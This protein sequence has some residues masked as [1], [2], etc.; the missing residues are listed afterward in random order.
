MTPR[1]SGSRSAVERFIS[2]GGQLCD[3]VA[4]DLD[5]PLSTIG[6]ERFERP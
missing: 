3:G 1:C 5:R 4:E 2:G 6:V